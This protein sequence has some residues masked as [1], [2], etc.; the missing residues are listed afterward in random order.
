MKQII[1]AIKRDDCS[2]PINI[3]YGSASAAIEAH[4]ASGG[5]FVIDKNVAGIYKDIMPSQ[6]VFIF[7]ALEATKNIKSVEQMLMWLKDGGALRDSR[8][9][10]IGGGVTGDTAGFAAALYMRGIKLIQMPTTLL[11]MVDSSVGGKTG[12]NMGGIKNNIGAFHQ[13]TQVV[14]DVEFLE[15]LTDAQFLNGLAESIKI[16]CVYSKDFLKMINDNK[17]K[18]LKRDRETLLAIVSN[19]C[20]LKAEVVA[21]DEKES[22]LRKLLNFGHTVAHAIETDSDYSINHGYAVAMGMIY[23]SIFALENGYTDKAAFNLIKDT[24][25]NFGYPECY[26]PADEARF[27]SALGKDKK[28]SKNGISLAVAGVCLEGKVIEGVEPK[29]LC[30][31]V[32]KYKDGYK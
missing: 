12:V 17:D 21:L 10:A 19:S 22:G 29:E 26:C 2:Y 24:L 15:S 6:R 23:E 32:F 18:I 5:F 25:S 20:M 3:D 28:A 11:A 1:V 31:L 13:P 7:E 27:L 9:M 30:N 4:A 16:G 8:L 14:I